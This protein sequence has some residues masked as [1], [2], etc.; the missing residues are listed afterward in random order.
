MKQSDKDK[1]WVDYMVTQLFLNT[2]YF[3]G[4]I[5]IIPLDEFHED[6]VE[7]FDSWTWKW[8]ER[9]FNN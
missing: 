5:K 2:L 7:N 9:I 3:N 6:G 4:E 1:V 8:G